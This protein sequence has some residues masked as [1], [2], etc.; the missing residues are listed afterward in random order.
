MSSIWLSILF[1]APWLAAIVG[2][3]SRAPRADAVPPSLGERAR[4]RLSTL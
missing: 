2:A 1:G 3:W 4:Q